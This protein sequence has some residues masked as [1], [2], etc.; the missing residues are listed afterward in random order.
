MAITA[1]NLARHRAIQ[2]TNN[3]FYT[4]LSLWIITFPLHVEANEERNFHQR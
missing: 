2:V 4:E 3:G 1:Q